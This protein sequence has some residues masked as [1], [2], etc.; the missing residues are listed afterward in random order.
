V[1]TPSARFVPEDP[2]SLAPATRARAATLRRHAAWICVAL[3]YLTV[4]P[5][6]AR[7][8]NPN[9]NVRIW[10]TRA[11]VDFHELNINRAS[12]TWG[13][14]ND[15][16]VVGGRLYS[17][18]APGA[19]LLGVPI[20]A[21]ERAVARLFHAEPSLRA[22]TL[23]LRFFGVGVPLA[24]FLFF[25]A[26]WAERITGSSGARD[27]LVVGLGLGSILYPYGVIFVGHA[28][29]AALAFSAFMLLSIEAPGRAR[30]GRLAWAGALAGAAVL[31]E[32]QAGIATAV[33]GA[34]A[35]ARHRRAALWFAL[36]AL[37]AVAVFGLYHAV[38]FGRPWE[39]PFGHLENPLWAQLPKQ[40]GHPD[41]HAAA[42]V[43]FSIDMGLFIFSPYLLLGVAGALVALVREE[44]FA[45]ASILAVSVG[46][47][48]FL[49]ALPNWH[50]G[51]CVGPRYISAI[52]PF[53]TAGLAYAW[54]AARR[55]FVLSALAAGLVVPSVLLNVVSGAVY[56]HYPEAFDNPVFDLTLPLIRD[57][58]VPYSLGWLLGLPRAWS[59]LPLALIV[60]AALVRAL[61]GEDARPRRRLAHAALA[62]AVAAA[63]LVPL[64][65]YGRTPSPAEDAA[66]AVVRAAWEPPPT[67][68][69]PPRR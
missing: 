28:L 27:L 67:P 41:P 15:K 21:A 12:A 1:Q 32:Y 64:S 53:L 42:G 14:V 19:S 8:N 33:V 3:A 37:P 56:P 38:V 18:K 6:Y 11:I 62:L 49:A 23:A 13:Y 43:L 69:P 47:V 24:I 25:F 9:E 45:G 40:V 57:G 44:R 54:R 2:L 60:V 4:F 59:L 22:V 36:G 51:W 34:Y 55:R 58:Y 46:L 65:R 63:F 20:Y 48:C 30:R 66:T 16:A 29:A 68:K 10:M 31:F 17:S 26:R 35:L 7:I 50:A 61:A 39:L 5:Y 52:A